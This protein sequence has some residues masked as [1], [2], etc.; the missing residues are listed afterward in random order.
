GAPDRAASRTPGRRRC[1]CA[2]PRGAP[3]VA[4]ATGPLLPHR[5]APPASSPAR[6]RSP[7]TRRDPS[8]SLRTSPR[9]PPRARR[10]E[11]QPGRSPPPRGPSRSR[12]SSTACASRHQL[13]PD[14]LTPL[15]DAADLAKGLK[16][17]GPGGLCGALEALTDGLVVESVYL[18]LEKREPL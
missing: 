17:V 14:Q 16:Y 3:P 13:L 8:G 15:E 6:D 12:C 1:D 9:A 18:S 4:R 7:D 5:P 11:R 2:D 10:W